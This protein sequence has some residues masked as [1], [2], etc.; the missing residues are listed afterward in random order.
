MLHAADAAIAAVSSIEIPAHSGTC[1]SASVANDGATAL[2]TE[3]SATSTLP[4]PST[5][6][7]EKRTSE[8]AARSATAAASGAATIRS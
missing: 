6:R 1:A 8:R 3:P 4:A 2:A 5:A 7:G